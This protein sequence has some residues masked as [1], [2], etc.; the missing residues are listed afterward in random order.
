MHKPIDMHQIK[1]HEKLYLENKM[2]V[3]PSLYMSPSEIGEI[4]S[5]RYYK[6]KSH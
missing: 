1:E 6:G 2:R 5:K 3:E 4:K